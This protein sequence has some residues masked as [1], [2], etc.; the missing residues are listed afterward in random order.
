M[1]WI[2]TALSGV[3]THWLHRNVALQNFHLYTVKRELLSTFMINGS[4][5]A[6]RSDLENI[7]LNK[8]DQLNH[9]AQAH[10]RATTIATGMELFTFISFVVSLIFYIILIVAPIW[11][12]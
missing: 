11:R 1:P 8:T 2:V 4:T 10:N 6:T 9:I 7:L 12:P 5:N 3:I